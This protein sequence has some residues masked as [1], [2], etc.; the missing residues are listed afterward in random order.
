MAFSFKKPRKT[1]DDPNCPFHGTL[2][3]RG[4]V[5]EGVVVSARM[6]KTVVVRRDYLKY[7]PKFKR[8]ER[9]HSHIPAHSPPC[10]S[11]EEGNRVRIAECRP[12]S[13]TVSF[14]V[15]EKTGGG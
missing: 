12:I 5:M 6:D 3:T 9:R 13:K 2:S 8:Y 15:V 1:C 4:R 11:V 10:I 7:K 14:V